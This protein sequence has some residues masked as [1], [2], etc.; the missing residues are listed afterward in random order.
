MPL[1]GLS[2]V[3]FFPERQAVDYIRRACAY[4]GIN[5]A[6][7]VAKWKEAKSRLTSSVGT[8]G[9]PDIQE[10]PVSSHPYLAQVPHNARFDATVRGFSSWSFQLVEIAPLLAFQFHVCMDTGAP[11]SVPT[12]EEMLAECLPHDVGWISYADPVVSHG[13]TNGSAV[14]RCDD[15]NLVP[16]MLDAG[17]KLGN[18]MAKLEFLGLPYGPSSPFVQVVRLDGRCYLKN[19]YHRAF[20][21]A[22]RGATHIPCVFLEGA[23][24][25][26]VTNAP[27]GS[28]F[29]Q[30][31]LTTDNPPTCGHFADGRAYEV[32]L[33]KASRVIE[34]NWRTRVDLE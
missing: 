4:S 34:V 8:P 21:S 1:P 3:G 29:A 30:A 33:R 11:R 7:A 22:R 26:D 9:L 18:Q 28:T 13:P 32:S 19:G 14:I 12:V 20:R 25:S 16:M 10:L 23:R 24:W 31:Q 6:G 27:V 17:V 5:K 2:L 15:L